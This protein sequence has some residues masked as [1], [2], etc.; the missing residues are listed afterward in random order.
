[1]Y[2]NLEPE[3]TCEHCGKKFSTNIVYTTNPPQ[4]D[5]PYCRKSMF[6]GPIQIAIKAD[7]KEE[8]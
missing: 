7:L 5:C 3:Y 1:M 8:K 2:N 6:V 4:V